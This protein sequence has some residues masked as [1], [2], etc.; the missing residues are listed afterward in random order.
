MFLSFSILCLLVALPLGVSAV[1]PGP[2]STEDAI[3]TETNPGDPFFGPAPSGVPP[4]AIG[5]VLDSTTLVTTTST[6]TGSVSSSSTVLTYI[7]CGN[8]DGCTGTI[9]ELVPTSSIKNNPTS[10]S[11]PVLTSSSTPH[12][13]SPD[14]SSS[15]T[16]PLGFVREATRILNWDID[17]LQ[18]PCLN[19]GVVNFLIPVQA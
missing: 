13:S 6:W 2:E 8:P 3:A 17:K 7:F 15:T 5:I 12:T 16:T 4:T 11:Q 1:D 18:F 14:S 10:T 9:I 19:R